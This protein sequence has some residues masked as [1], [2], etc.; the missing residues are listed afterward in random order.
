ML[1][2]V[3][4]GGGAA[5]LLTAGTLVGGLTTGLAGAHTS[6][7][8][9]RI[10]QA[11]PDQATPEAQDGAA[12]DGADTPITLPAGSISQ[13]AARQAAEAYIQQTA[14]YNS[15]GL[16][17]THVTVDDEDGTAVYKVEFSGSNGQSVE[18][19]VSAQGKVLKAEAGNDGQEKA[20]SEGAT[21]GVDADGPGGPNVQSGD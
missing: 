6:N 16:S 11:A 7:Q 15:Q 13:D 8:Q 17:A 10:A 4:L 18:V 3:V 9:A 12:N 2:K 21:P 19:T 20:G 14:P 5:V 1:S